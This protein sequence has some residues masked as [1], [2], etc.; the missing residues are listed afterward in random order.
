MVQWL[1]KVRK[2]EIFEKWLKYIGLKLVGL[3]LK[4]EIQRQILDRK[5]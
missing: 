4:E 2:D 3:N 1:E 5:F